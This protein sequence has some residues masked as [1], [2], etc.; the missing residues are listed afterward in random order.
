M[1]KKPQ[2]V[3]FLLPPGSRRVN[4]GQ[5]IFT[6]CCYRCT[7]KG[8]GAR[9]KDLGMQSISILKSLLSIL[10]TTKLGNRALYELSNE[11]NYWLG[12]PYERTTW[13][14][15]VEERSKAVLK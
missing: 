1:Y 4:I 8:D 10:K 6:L 3:C 2:Y 11:T 7:P 5:S 12:F 14:G 9:V 15:K 13:Q